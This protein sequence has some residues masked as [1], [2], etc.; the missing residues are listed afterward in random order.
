MS[1]ISFPSP[2]ERADWWR[3]LD[4][5][6]SLPTEDCRRLLDAVEHVQ[7]MEKDAFAL[8]AVYAGSRLSSW[9]SRGGR[10]PACG[11]GEAHALAA[12]LRRAAGVAPA[13]PPLAP[14]A[15]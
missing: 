10:C 3:Q 8:A 1:S 6:A 5:G 13:S 9:D 15:T 12:W 11:D 14:Q 2:D 7:A 4:S